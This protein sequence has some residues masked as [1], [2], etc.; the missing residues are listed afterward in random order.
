[1]DPSKFALWSQRWGNPGDDNQTYPTTVLLRHPTAPYMGTGTIT[2]FEHDLKKIGHDYLV[3]A[4]SNHLVDPAL[5]LPPEWLDALDPDHPSGD[6]SFEWLP[7]E[8]PG[9]QKR[10][11]VSFL[12]PRTDAS[13]NVSD[14]MVIMLA[15]QPTGAG[16]GI[17]VVTHVRKLESQYRSQS[18]SQ[19]EIRI[20]G[21]S[22]SLPF[23]HFRPRPVQHLTRAAR[24]REAALQ[25]E[26]FINFLISG[27]FREYDRINAGL[28]KRYRCDLGY[29]LVADHA[30]SGK[31]KLRTC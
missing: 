12:A 18:G 13:N 10:S 14:L 11:L 16:F 31:R 15:S 26:I 5:G 19:F 2:N 9:T 25:S 21:M 20:S 8:R 7:L 28:G 4:N 22:A 30:R 1:M 27:E 17:R 29:A 24:T 3:A 23:G 6:S